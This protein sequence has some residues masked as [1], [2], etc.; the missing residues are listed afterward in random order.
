[1]SEEK[2][3]MPVEN[4]GDGHQLGKGPYVVTSYEFRGK[5]WAFTDEWRLAKRIIGAYPTREE[6]TELAFCYALDDRYVLYDVREVMHGFM[7]PIF[8]I[9]SEKAKKRVEN[10]LKSYKDSEKERLRNL[11]ESEQGNVR[12]YLRELEGMDE[13]EVPLGTLVEKEPSILFA[14]ILIH[15]YE[16]FLDENDYIRIGMYGPKEYPRFI[17]GVEE[18]RGYQEKLIKG[19][20]ST[21]TQ[22]NRKVLDDMKKSEFS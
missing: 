9:N 4:P 2:P 17:E 19:F 7:L 1:M 21:K 5:Q 18:V 14:P 6:S 3:D 13:K 20:F 12:E 16:G 8:G 22:E 11:I 10:A 15:G